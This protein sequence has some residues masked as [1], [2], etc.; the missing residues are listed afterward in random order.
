MNLKRIVGSHIA[1]LQEQWECNRLFKLGRL[2]P[3]LSS[4]FD[5]ADVGEATRLVQRNGHL[6]KVGVLCLAP[7]GGLGVTATEVRVRIG[8]QRLNPM[9][10]V[11]VY[12]PTPVMAG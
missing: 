10:Q 12:A 9:R 3:V 8:E 11:A 1:N 6:G 5:L 7:S 4:V 2:V